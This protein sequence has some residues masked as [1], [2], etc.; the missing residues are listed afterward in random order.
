MLNVTFTQ[1]GSVITATIDLAQR[2]H[3]S[4]GGKSIIIASSGGNQIIGT[5]E[6]EGKACPI[7]LGLNCFLQYASGK[8]P[9]EVK[10][11]S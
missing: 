11:I 3:T 6:Y 5:A 10:I 7:K 4:A 1:K 9:A 8:G 2:H